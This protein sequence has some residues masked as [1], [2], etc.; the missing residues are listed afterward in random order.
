MGASIPVEFRQEN[1]KV[2]GWGDSLY[3]SAQLSC[4]VRDKA[5]HAA[6]SNKQ[7]AQQYNVS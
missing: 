1:L 4:T 6:Q 2:S 7:L 5:G 3:E